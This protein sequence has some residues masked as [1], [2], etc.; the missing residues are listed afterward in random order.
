MSALIKVMGMLIVL[1]I[2]VNCTFWS[3]LGC[4]RQKVT[5]FAHSGITHGYAKE[6][7][8]KCCDTDHTVSIKEIKKYG[9]LEIY[10]IAVSVFSPLGVSLSLSHTHI[11]LPWGF[12]FN[13]PTSIPVT[14]IIMK[15][16]P[17]GI[18]VG[19]FLI[20]YTKLAW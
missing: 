12:N 5:V 14:F 17:R 11:G 6:I 20:Y 18:F 1:F 15:V 13:F 7:Y 8:K 16:P 19:S 4:L 9:K 2:G 10:D 3:H